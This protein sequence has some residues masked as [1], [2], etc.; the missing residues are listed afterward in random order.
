MGGPRQIIFTSSTLIPI[1]DRK[2]ISVHG[3]RSFKDITSWIHQRV[4]LVSDELGI[5][6]LRNIYIKKTFRHHH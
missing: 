1:T 2:I 3:A 6:M 4:P 5:S